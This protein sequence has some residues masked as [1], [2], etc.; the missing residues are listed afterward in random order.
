MLQGLAVERVGEGHSM[1]QD[2]VMK[3]Y[4]TPQ[5]AQ[6][7]QAKTPAEKEAEKAAALAIGKN[8]LIPGI[9]PNQ[10]LYT[11]PM[12]E[13]GDKYAELG[14]YV[15]PAEKAGGLG[16]PFAY[17]EPG[18]PDDVAYTG[19]DAFKTPQAIIPQNGSPI[20]GT[21]APSISEPV[22]QAEA[23]P[24]YSEPRKQMG[25]VKN[26]LRG[27]GWA[28]FL[29]AATAGWLGKEGRYVSQRD[30]QV[31]KAQEVAAKAQERIDQLEMLSQELAL[32]GQSDAAAQVESEASDMR[33][34]K[35]QQKFQAR[36]NALDRKASASPEQ[37]KFAQYMAT[38]S[39][40]MKGGK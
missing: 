13:Q 23:D 21:G 4:A 40:A 25:T 31:A 28:D 14:K 37:D 16:M 30:A 12:V 10:K 6:E 8:S 39:A 3:L 29:E 18:G 1:T 7:F 20:S 11:D 27:P 19:L 17:K 15:D 5:P 35:A 34:L 36:E 22:A 32:R 2:D 33:K 26:T 38:L 9:A 24:Y